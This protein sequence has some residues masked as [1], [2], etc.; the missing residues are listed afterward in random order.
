MAQT[1][2]QGISVDPGAT[3]NLNDNELEVLRLL[4][5]ESPRKPA[6]IQGAFGIWIDFGNQGIRISGNV[7]Y[8]TEAATVFLE[9]NHGFK[10]LYNLKGGILAW[11]DEID[12]SIKKY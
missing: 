9:M 6:E 11:A 7:I 10:N 4:W 5:D 8:N 3:W 2:N 12:D 1:D